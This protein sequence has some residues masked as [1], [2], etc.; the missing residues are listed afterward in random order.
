MHGDAFRIDAY[1]SNPTTVPGEKCKISNII[2]P[3]EKY[4]ATYNIRV[5]RK[6]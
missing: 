5:S 4:L 6:F 2:A 1:L 3:D